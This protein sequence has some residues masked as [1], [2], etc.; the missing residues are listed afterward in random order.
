[1]I[2]GRKI[3][4][5]LWELFSHVFGCV[6]CDAT[7]AASAVSAPQQQQQHQGLLSVQSMYTCFR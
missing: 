2:A 1:M 3:L 6:C 5:I 4:H 7:V